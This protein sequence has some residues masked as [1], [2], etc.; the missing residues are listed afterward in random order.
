MK[1]TTFSSIP[2]PALLF[3]KKYVS[4]PLQAIFQVDSEAIITCL[5]LLENSTENGDKSIE[6]GKDFQIC[7]VAIIPNRIY[8]SATKSQLFKF[9]RRKRIGF[10]CFYYEYRKE[11]DKI[12]KVDLMKEA[13]TTYMSFEVFVNESMLS[14]EK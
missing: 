8:V 2:C 9:N 12:V 14:N 5:D 1:A 11:K 3:N 6:S 4:D 7:S 10:V 13:P